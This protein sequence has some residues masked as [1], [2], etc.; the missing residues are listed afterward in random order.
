MEFQGK[1][2]IVA[3]AGGGIGLQIANDLL[4]KGAN[5]ILADLKPRPDDIVDSGGTAHY[6][7]GDLSDEGFVASVVAECVSRYGGPDCL[8]NT[9]AVLWFDRDRS[10]VDTDVETWRRVMDINLGSYMLTAKFTVPAMQARGG[11]AM[12]HFAS[13]DALKGDPQPQDAYAISK[14]AVMRLS[15]SIAV[16]YAPDG[17]RSN[18][19]LPGPVL[20]P[21]QARWAGDTETQQKV[22]SRIPLGR[23]GTPRDQSNACL[24]LLSDD[25]SFITG[26][27]LIVDGGISA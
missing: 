14:A 25:A 22:A 15:R 12:V 9:A 26:T 17:I 18:T 10:L 23:L 16:Q 3:G 24:F 19:I 8:V 7:E 20:S 11:G 4:A 6:L 2:A 13:I 27:E 1:N 5:V 21:M